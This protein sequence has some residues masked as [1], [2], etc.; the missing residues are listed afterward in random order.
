MAMQVGARLFRTDEAILTPDWLP[1]ECII[2]V[3]N[4]AEREFFWSNRAY[5]AGRKSYNE[6]VKRSNDNGDDLVQA[7]VQSKRG[8]G[9]DLLLEQW[10]SFLTAVEHGFISRGPHGRPSQGQICDSEF[11]NSEGAEQILRRFV[12]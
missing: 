5:A 10:S 6:R 9:M 8:R 4:A 1:N 2:C 3:Y 12:F 11:V 7:M